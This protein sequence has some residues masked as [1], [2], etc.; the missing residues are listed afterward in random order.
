M[1]ANRV[2]EI[3]GWNELKFTLD[4]TKRMIRYLGHKRAPLPVLKQLHEITDGW[5]AGIVLLMEGIY[6]SI[7]PIRQSDASL[8]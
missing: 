4:E 3:I 2:M 8:P 6:P 1:R 5:A 7:S